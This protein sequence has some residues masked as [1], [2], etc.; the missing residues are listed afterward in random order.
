MSL[1]S[2]FLD[3]SVVAFRKLEVQDSSPSVDF[4]GG[5]NAG[6]SNSCGIGINENVPDLVGTPQQFTLDDQKEQ[7]RT[8]QDSQ[9]IG[10]IALGDGLSTTNVPLQFGAN[11]AGG[12]GI[13]IPVGTC[14]LVDLAAG[15]SVA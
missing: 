10:G 5:M 12:T 7:P 8:P 15:W 13:M 9:A 14:T 2:Y 6:G 3:D 1:P 11:S 4:A